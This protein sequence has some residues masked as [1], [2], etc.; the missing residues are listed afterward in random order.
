MGPID[1][2]NV[3]KFRGHFRGEDFHP[4]DRTYRKCFVSSPSFV[5]IYICFWCCKVKN[6]SPFERSINHQLFSTQA[7]DLRAQAAK[8]LANA[9]TSEFKICIHAIRRRTHLIPM[10]SQKAFRKKN[11]RSDTF[12]KKLQTPNDPGSINSHY[13]HIIGDK[14]INP[15]P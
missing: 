4:F 2:L 10:K 15:S 1:V 12:Q 8:L 13:F 7:T 14:L 6:V 3:V 11:I 5:G 9:R